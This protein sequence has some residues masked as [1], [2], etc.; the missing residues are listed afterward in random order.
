MVW[1]YLNKRQQSVT[2]PAKQA[3]IQDSVQ[4]IGNDNDS[5]VDLNH[6][7]NKIK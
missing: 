5:E 4:E 7:D 2:S 1:A 6:D 3:M